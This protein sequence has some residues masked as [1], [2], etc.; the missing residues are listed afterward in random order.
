MRSAKFRSTPRRTSP[1]GAGGNPATYVWINDPNLGAPGMRERSYV[2]LCINISGVL[3][4]LS[5]VAVK[6]TPR[7]YG[8]FPHWHTGLCLLA[9]YDSGRSVSP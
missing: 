2:I 9:Q 6:L 1:E 3:A 7:P 8:R 4:W 5:P